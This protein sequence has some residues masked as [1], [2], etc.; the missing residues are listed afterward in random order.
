M[1]DSFGMEEIELDYTGVPPRGAP[2]RVNDG[3]RIARYGQ[4]VPDVFAGQWIEDETSR[5]VAFTESVEEHLE[6]I[7][8]MVYAP[9][10]VRAVRFRYS[11]RHLLDL[12]HRI[13]EILGT[14]DGLTSWGPDVKNNL[15]VVS[16]LPE[17][18]DEV[19]RMLMETNPDDVRVEPGSP[20]IAL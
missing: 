1:A 16:V 6:A 5:V 17:R 15:V 4:S 7:R 9:Q 10:R 3:T 19:R 18:I 11:Y 20:V 8:R 12:T 13:V 14:S 2:A